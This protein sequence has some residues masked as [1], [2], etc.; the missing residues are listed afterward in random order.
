MASTAV[1]LVKQVQCFG[2]TVKQYSHE[3]AINKCTMQFCI[4]L[5]PA[6]EEK[7]VP[8]V[9]YLAGLTCNEELMMI[10]GGAQRVASEKG[11]AIVAPDTSA[12]GVD[13]EGQDDSY[14]FGSAAGFYLDA[15]EPKWKEHY[16]MYSYVTKVCRRS[17]QLYEYPLG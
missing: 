12:R 13:I 4:Y 2:G 10:K 15:I 5:P 16:N 9:Y 1:K 17:N 6:A 14:D 7:N 11:I 8:V 3:S